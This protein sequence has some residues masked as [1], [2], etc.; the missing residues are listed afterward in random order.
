M[1]VGDEQILPAVVVNVEETGP[2]SDVFLTDGPDAG[3]GGAVKERHDPRLAIV[4]VEGVLL[5]LVIRHPERRPAAAIIVGRV[6]A[7][8]AVR[9]AVVVA[10]RR[11]LDAVF[12]NLKCPGVQ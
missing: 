5:V 1:A 4:V 12:V 10:G 6:H 3:R 11:R 7:H 8:A 2:P 9:G